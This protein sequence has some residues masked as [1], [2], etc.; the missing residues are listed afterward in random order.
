MTSG[1]TAEF[2]PLGRSQ[3]R[4]KRK[5][6]RKNTREE[7]K[8]HW[9]SSL[10]WLWKDFA[11]YPGRRISPPGEQKLV[12]RLYFSLWSLFLAVDVSRWRCCRPIADTHVPEVC[13]KPPRSQRRRF[14]SHLF[15]FSSFFSPFLFYFS[16]QQCECVGHVMLWAAGPPSSSFSRCTAACQ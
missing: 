12:N 9:N 8:T 14:F 1:R 13:V 10:G 15:F 2:A 3:L 5:K 7:K 16:G 4:E 11:N 6:N